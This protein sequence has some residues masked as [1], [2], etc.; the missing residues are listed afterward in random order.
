[1]FHVLGWGLL[2]TAISFV[3]ESDVVVF[4]KYF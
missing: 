3:L 1:M 4:Y 2:N